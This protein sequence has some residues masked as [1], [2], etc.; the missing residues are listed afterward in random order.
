MT[1]KRGFNSK[2]DAM[3]ERFLDNIPQGNIAYLIAFLN[4]IFYAAYMFWPKYK[5]H[6]YLN[7]FSFSLYGFN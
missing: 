2:I 7:N 4:T 3:L 1:A 5:I 6:S